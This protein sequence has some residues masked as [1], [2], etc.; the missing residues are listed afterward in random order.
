MYNVNYLLWIWDIQY[1]CEM[2]ASADE[3]AHPRAY[4]HTKPS[5][6][7]LPVLCVQPKRVDSVY[8]PSGHSVVRLRIFIVL[9]FLKEG[10]QD[11]HF[12][13]VEIS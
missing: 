6:K 8:N 2:A 10:L 3:C 11:Q 5:K 12:I 7:R 4:R 9:A 1:L 13:S